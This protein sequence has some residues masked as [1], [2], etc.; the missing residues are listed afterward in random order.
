MAPPLLNQWAPMPPVAHDAL[1]ATTNTLPLLL[2][3]IVLFQA[4]VPSVSV[5]PQTNW[6][7]LV[8][9]PA[10]H[11]ALAGPIRHR[12]LRLVEIG[13]ASCRERVFNWV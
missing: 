10:G 13:R 9:C 8:S 7:P 4:L 5:P 3:T 2:M 12:A 6:T 11:H 1:P